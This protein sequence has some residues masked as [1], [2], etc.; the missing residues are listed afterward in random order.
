MLNE[1]LKIYKECLPLTL[2]YNTE[3]SLRHSIEVCLQKNCYT[4]LKK[5]EKIIGFVESYRVNEEQA[6]HLIVRAK[7]LAIN[8]KPFPVP[9]YLDLED[10]EHGEISWVENVAIPNKYRYIKVTFELYRLY[11]EKYRDSKVHIGHRL[12][13]ELGKFIILGGFNG[14]RERRNNN[15]ATRRKSKHAVRSN[16]GR[17][18]T[19]AAQSI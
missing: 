6:E 5:D 2:V 1:L 15:T 17:V 14:R 8:L 3:D 16:E 10:L 9:F 18:A 13:K 7:Y 4:I 11:R 19:R 12:G